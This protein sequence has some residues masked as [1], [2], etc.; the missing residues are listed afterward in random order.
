MLGRLALAACVTPLLAACGGDTTRSITAPQAPAATVPNAS[1]LSAG[2][3]ATPWQALAPPATRTISVKAVSAN[4]TPVNATY[5]RVPRTFSVSFS[6]PVTKMSVTVAGPSGAPLACTGVAPTGMPQS[7]LGC[8]VSFPMGAPTGTWRLAEVAAV[9]G[10]TRLAQSGDDLLDA[11]LGRI[12]LHVVGDSMDAKAP[13]VIDVGAMDMHHDT[14][15]G[16]DTWHPVTA[17]IKDDYRG[18]RNA[19]AFVSTPSGKV[20]SCSLTLV[21]YIM[22]TEPNEWTCTLPLNGEHGVYTITTITAADSSGNVSSTAAETVLAG[23]STRNPRLTF[24]VP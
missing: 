15:A 21:W 23:W 7:T 19:S 8:T 12:A 11:G 13:T 14:H 4:L 1:D 3:A 6:K 22:P 5:W 2:G 17:Y 20:L 16:T 9:N 24:T 10:A 18:V